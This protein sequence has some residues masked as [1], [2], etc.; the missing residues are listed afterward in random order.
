MGLFNKILHAGE[1]R[2]LKAVQA[3]VPEVNAL[4]A[5]D[6][7]IV[8]RPAR[9]PRRPSSSS[10]STTPAA[11]AKNSDREKATRRRRPRRHPARGLRRRPRGRQAGARP[12]AL[13]RPGH[14]RRGAA[15]RLGRGDEDRRG[16]DA[17]LDAARVPQRA[18]G[19]G[20]APRHGER[21]PRPPRRG[22]DGAVA[23]LPRPHGRRRRSRRLDARGEARPV[24]LRPHVRHQQRGRLRLPARQHGRR[25]SKTRCSAGCATSRGRRTTSA[26]STRSTRSSSTRLAPRSSSRA[27]PPTP[28]SSTTSSPGS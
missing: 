22:V 18:R 14:G 21:L 4:G 20:R 19:P 8:R 11:D 17:R 27:A 15:P 28:P 12:T 25:A 7:A 6:R 13:R 26:S 24:Q 2:R 5:R 23:P 3:I 10:G 9:R 16:Q 1:G